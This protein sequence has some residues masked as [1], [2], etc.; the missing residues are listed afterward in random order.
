M[1]K[2]LINDSVSKCMVCSGCL[3]LSQSWV[4]KTTAVHFAAQT[5]RHFAATSVKNSNF[6][7]G[8]FSLQMFTQSPN[9]TRE[10]QVCRESVKN[11]LENSGCLFKA[12]IFN[13]SA[14]MKLEYK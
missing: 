8:V 5:D 13:L 1:R 2:M 12:S 6:F 4:L 9:H 7:S 14:S 11:M 10:C 3:P